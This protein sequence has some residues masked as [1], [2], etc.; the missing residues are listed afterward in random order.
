MD[1]CAVIAK[2]SAQRQAEFVQR[3]KTAG[4]VKVNGLYAHP[5][6]I[7]AIREAVEKIARRRVRAEQKAQKAK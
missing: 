4:L 6:D 2:T 5:D 7:Q 1:A 3:Q